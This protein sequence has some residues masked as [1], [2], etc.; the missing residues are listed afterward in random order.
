MSNY[1]KIEY[2]VVGVTFENRQELWA[3]IL[4]SFKNDLTVDISLENE[5]DNPYDSN[6]V[7]VKA[8]IDGSKRSVG[9]LPK[10]SNLQFRS[11]QGR[12]LGCSLKS[13]GAA[14][15]GNIGAKLVVSFSE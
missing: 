5:D 8:V 1:V 12:F 2:P 15:N 10:G 3:K 4:E 9:Y 7:A 14:A 11:L 6:A 13:V